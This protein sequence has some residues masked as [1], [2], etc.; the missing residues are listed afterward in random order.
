MNPQSPISVAIGG[1]LFICLSA[2]FL[3]VGS[4]SHKVAALSDRYS[5]WLR[6]NPRSGASIY[7]LLELV[8]ALWMLCRGVLRLINQ[9]P[10]ASDDLIFGIIVLV[11]AILTA[12]FYKWF[13]HSR[14]KKLERF[15]DLM[16]RYPWILLLAGV[17]SGV[18]GVAMLCSAVLR[19]L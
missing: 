10:N 15:A 9:E 18:I 2:Y 6:R 1:S 4:F 16:R 11:L 19:M 12:V 17:A 8:V 14:A 5:A 7:V 3:F 13:A